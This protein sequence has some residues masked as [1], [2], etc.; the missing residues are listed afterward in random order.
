MNS[1]IYIMTVVIKFYNIFIN[2][3]EHAS[4]I[5]KRHSMSFT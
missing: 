3:I 4:D 5:F 1:D 2:S